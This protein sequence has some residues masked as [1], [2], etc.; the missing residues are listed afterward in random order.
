MRYI[1]HTQQ[2]IK[3]INPVES[4]AIISISDR[5]DTRPKVPVNAQCVGVLNMTF[6]DVV[7]GKYNPKLI[8]M[9]DDAMANEILDFWLEHKQ[10]DSMYVHCAGGQCRSPGVAAAL[11]RLEIGNDDNWFASKRPNIL[12]YRLIL[13]QAYARNLHEA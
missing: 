1:V 12:V 9:F 5:E 10:A 11:Q 4:H 13:N 6:H 8:T 2:T 7:K 3:R